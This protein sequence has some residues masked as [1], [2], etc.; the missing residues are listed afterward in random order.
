[1]TDEIDHFVHPVMVLSQRDTRCAV[2]NRPR[3]QVWSRPGARPSRVGLTRRSLPGS[4]SAGETGRDIDAGTPFDPTGLGGVAGQLNARL[5][6]VTVV[7]E[8]KLGRPE[9][10]EAMVL[11]ELRNPV[12]SGSGV[13]SMLNTLSKHCKLY[14]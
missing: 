12:S 10:I 1:M 5:A 4:E 3:T 11:S 8:V 6:A 14:D 7:R 2:L 13:T 9:G